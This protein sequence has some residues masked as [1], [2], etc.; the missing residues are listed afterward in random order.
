[1]V[2]SGRSCRKTA[3]LSRPGRQGLQDLGQKFRPSAGCR[4]DHESIITALDQRSVYAVLHENGRSKAVRDK[5]RQAGGAP[6]PQDL[7]RCL[8]ESCS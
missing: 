8:R 2:D 4:G 3:L 1:M 6:V 7:P 5:Q